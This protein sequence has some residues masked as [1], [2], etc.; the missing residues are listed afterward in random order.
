MVVCTGMESGVLEEVRF[1]KGTLESSYE[2]YF[3]VLVDTDGYLGCYILVGVMVDM[4]T[5]SDGRRVPS[6]F[7]YML[8]DWNESNSWVYMDEQF[9]KL[10]LLELTFDE[11]IQLFRH[12][13][14]D[15]LLKLGVELTKE[16][17]NG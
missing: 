10:R 11:F 9:G 13:T 8:L 2:I 14:E 12:A 6:R 4:K 5:L 15:E 16:K 7:Y 3:N 1:R 17:G